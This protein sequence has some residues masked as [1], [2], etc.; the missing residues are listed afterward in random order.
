M[1]SSIGHARHVKTRNDIGLQ[2]WIFS[3]KLSFSVVKKC[4]KD[5]FRK[6]N[7]L[8]IYVICINI[9]D[10]V[11]F[12]WSC[13]S[14]KSVFSLSCIDVFECSTVNCKYQCYRKQQKANSI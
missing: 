14:M 12:Q 1:S 5:K 4:F 9:S 6:N 3:Q 13:G 8:S 11:W 2:I 10:L 7:T